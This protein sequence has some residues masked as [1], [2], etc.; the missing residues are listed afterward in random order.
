MTTRELFERVA[1]HLLAQGKR[2]MLY[3]SC[4]Y[5]GEDGTRC[6]VGC[7]IDDAHYSVAIEDATIASMAVQEAVEGTIGRR[8][9]DP[10]R[11]M[12]RDLQALH[13]ADDPVFWPQRLET[14]RREWF[15][16]AFS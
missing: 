4:R 13:D 6:A 2:S 10:E 14:K 15:P 16:E 11:L 12:L 5:R 8:L 9:T 1:A 3:K 7:L